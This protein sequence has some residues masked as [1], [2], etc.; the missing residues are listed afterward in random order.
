MATPY[1]FIDR[2]KSKVKN[3]LHVSSIIA[4]RSERVKWIKYFGSKVRLT[5]RQR[6]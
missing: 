2:L 5:T 4:F 1:D 3:S 6:L